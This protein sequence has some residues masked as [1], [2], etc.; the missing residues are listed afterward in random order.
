MICTIVVYASTVN[1]NHN[2]TFSSLKSNRLNG[3]DSTP[4]YVGMISIASTV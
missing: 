1:E 2:V 4:N 3:C